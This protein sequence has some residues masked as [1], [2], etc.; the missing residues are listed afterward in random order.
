[1]RAHF[2]GDLQHLARHR[3]FEIHPSFQSSAQVEHILVL[4]MAAV[5]PQMQGNQVS[6]GRF[7]FERG[8]DR[9]GV[10]RAT[11]LA[12]GGDVINVDTEFERSGHGGQSR[13]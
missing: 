10:S 11:H 12:Q 1:M 9:V 2:D 6:A 5:F 8:L 4:N 3:C 13:R 7:G